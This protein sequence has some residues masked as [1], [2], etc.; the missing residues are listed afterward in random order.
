MKIYY[1]QDADIALIQSKKVAVIGY[2]SQ[3][4]AHALN[5]RDA[6]HNLTLGLRPGGP[7]WAR[8]VA[9]GFRPTPLETAVKGADVVVFLVPDMAQ[10]SVYK[11]H[12]EPLKPQLDRVPRPFPKLF[13][14]RNNRWLFQGAVNPA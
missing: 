8:A 7:T 2:G 13:F 12:V 9:D 6:G 5:L 14:K 11:N 1:E 4:R 10:P 3:G